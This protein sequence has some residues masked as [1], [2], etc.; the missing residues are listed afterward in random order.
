M[1]PLPGNG[2]RNTHRNPRALSTWRGRVQFFVTTIMINDIDNNNNRKG[3]EKRKTKNMKGHEEK[4]TKSLVHN[5][6]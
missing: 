2:Q 3:K 1:T 6:L 5:V 4:R